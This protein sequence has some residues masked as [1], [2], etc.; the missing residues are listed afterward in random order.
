[1]TGMW[2]VHMSGI[3]GQRRPRSARA[4]AQPDQGLHCPL[5]ELLDTTECMNGE[6]SPGWYLSHTQDDLNQRFLRM[7]EGTFSHANLILSTLV[8]Y[9][10]LC[11]VWI[12][13]EFSFFFYF[14]L[15]YVYAA[16]EPE[17]K[18]QQRKIFS[19]EFLKR[20]LYDL[21]HAYGPR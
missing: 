2:V 4:S 12:P 1:M 13:T 14:F 9:Y 15:F 16:L 21:M 8:I 3:C 20:L 5:I 17:Q 7:F 11:P 10:N 6:Q 19:T 18:T